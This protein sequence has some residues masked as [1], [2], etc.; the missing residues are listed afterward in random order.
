MTQS[1]RGLGLLGYLN[2]VDHPVR[3]K[4]IADHPESV[5]FPD[6]HPPMSGFLGVPI[7]HRKEHVGN[8][9]L[10]E[11]ERGQEFTK[12]DEDIASM[13]AAQAAAI[14]FNS[15]RYEE[16]RQAKADLE[17]LM[18]LS[19]VA[20][21]VFDALKGEI[22]YVNQESLRMLGALG[23][24]D[25]DIGGIFQ[26][27]RFTRPDGR[28]IPFLELPG[29]R[30]LQTGETI[31]AEEVVIHLPNGNTLT[32]LVSCAPLFSD[33][34]EMV[35]VLSVTQDLTPLEDM[36]RQKGE[37]M[38]RVSEE[39]RTPLTAIKGS[40][41]AL[42]GIVE[43]SS[44]GEHLQLLKIIDQQADLMRSQINSLLE[45]TQIEA[46]TLSVATEPA[47]VK[48]LLQRSCGEYL[49]DHAA[50]A[51]QMEIPDGLPPVL[52]DGHRI[53]QVLHNLLRQASAHSNVTSPVKV[54]ASTVD[55]YVAISVSVQ[56]NIAQREDAPSSH[57]NTDSLSL[58]EA[59]TQAHNR[60]AEMASQGEGLA[61]AFCRGVVE[62]HGGRI[63]TEV[64]EERREVTM[65]FTLPSVENEAEIL[66]A[67]KQEV[68]GGSPV[69]ET[70]NIHILAS[71]E[72]IKLQNAVRKVL[73]SAGYHAV[74]S[75]SLNDTLEYATAGDAKLILLDIAGRE[76]EC[77]RTLRRARES[78]NIPA[79]VLCDRDDEDYVVR[80]FDMGAD[81]YMV[82]PFSP[83]EMIARIKAAL[84]RVSAGR[85][86]N[87]ANTFT[88]GA[89]Q[90]NFLDRTVSVSGQPVQLTAT[91]YKLLTELAGAPGRIFTQDELLQR[92]W[93][94]EYSGEPQ[95]LRSYIKSLRQKLGDDA[96]KPLYIFTEHGI[97]YRIAKPDP[98]S[99]HPENRTPVAHLAADTGNGRK[100]ASN[101]ND[102]KVRVPSIGWAH[103]N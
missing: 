82:K 11:K 44:A 87:G 3:I 36:E 43:P 71:I 77:F 56:G 96:R 79:I 13:L 20:V 23:I 86:P 28:E 84:R 59:V 65:T 92:A 60:A 2:K 88:L 67:G 61:A 30:V 81:G 58:I 100:P 35:A 57:E 76:E 97:G 80:V 75:S 54:A 25:E 4:D 68:N 12:E 53:R 66:F 64:N 47:D 16:E 38:G 14:I 74:I 8:L 7:F 29:S 10:T 21:G 32:S 51:L 93:G 18:D 31:R 27:L 34:G 85:E 72:D 63:R 89:L 41:I 55:I 62:A 73:L 52:A 5:G 40:A 22:T 39:L 37:F 19:P 98:R 17:T 101:G 49:R 45:L 70:E 99:T 90:I 50:F 91:E 33:A 48:E 94:P 69:A 24:P 103:S 1:P 42:R 6:G 83:S 102:S 9:Y 46:G 78:L 26:N 95:L 15:R